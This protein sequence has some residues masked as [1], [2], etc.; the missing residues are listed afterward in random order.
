MPI[1]LNTNRGEEADENDNE[2]CLSRI[3]AILSACAWLCRVLP[4]CTSGEPAAGWRI[5]QLQHGRGYILAFESDNGLWQYGSWC[6]RA[7]E[8]HQHFL[9]YGRRLWNPV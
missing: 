4:D 5:C 3:H 2:Y 8:Q 1:Q 7:P 9:Q 6:A